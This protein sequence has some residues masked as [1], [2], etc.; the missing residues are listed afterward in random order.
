MSYQAVSRYKGKK[1]RPRGKGRNQRSGAYQPFPTAQNTPKADIDE[2]LSRAVSLLAHQDTDMPGLA[3]MPGRRIEFFEGLSSQCHFFDLSDPTHAPHIQAAVDHIMSKR[4]AAFDCEWYSVDP[5][6]P[7]SVMQFSTLSHTF[8]FHVPTGA[9]A[10]LVDTSPVLTRI[11]SDTLEPRPMLLVKD[12]RTDRRK[13]Q[14]TFGRPM[15]QVT[16]LHSLC[17]QLSFGTLNVK[18]ICEVLD[19]GEETIKCDKVSGSH[20]DRWPLEDWQ[21]VYAAFDPFFNVVCALRAAE[22]LREGAEDPTLPFSTLLS[23]RVQRLDRLD[24]RLIKENRYHQCRCPYRSCEKG[25][26][27]EKEEWVA[28]MALFHPE[29]AVQDYM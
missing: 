13:F 19:I 2:V 1:P 10:H 20:W 15:P 7:I 28:H 5:E 24:R 12:P 18:Q 11:L 6:S 16:D 21:Q 22:L 23:S 4:L 25:F 9:G 17:F 14:H 3:D 8:V 29:E 27:T 26:F